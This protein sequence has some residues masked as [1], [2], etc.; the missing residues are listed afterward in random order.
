MV[1]FKSALKGL[2][3]FKSKPAKVGLGIG[4]GVGAGSWGLNKLLTGSSKNVLLILV[5]IAL[6]IY[7]S[8]SNGDIV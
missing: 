6:V 7:I 3:L 4:G 5:G 2:K 1:I 8:E